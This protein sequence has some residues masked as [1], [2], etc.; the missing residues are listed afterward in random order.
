MSGGKFGRIAACRKTRHFH[1][2]SARGIQHHLE[3]DEG[4]SRKNEQ[5]KKP[6]SFSCA[7]ARSLIFFARAADVF[8]LLFLNVRAQASSMKKEKEVKRQTLLELVDYVNTSAGQKIF[9]EAAMPAIMAKAP[10]SFFDARVLGASV[11]FERR[12]ARFCETCV[13]GG[14]GRTCCSVEKTPAVSSSARVF[15]TFR[16]SV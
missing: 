13:V 2:S 14:R 1:A 8:V 5:D 16:E 11:L 4:L 9:T 7:R 3:R 12:H 10:A 6:V 15:H